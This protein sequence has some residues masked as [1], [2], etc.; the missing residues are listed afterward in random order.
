MILTPITSV[1]DL[2]EDMK[3]KYV[4]IVVRN[5]HSQLNHYLQTI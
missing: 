3:C 1:D 5:D 4:L 2:T